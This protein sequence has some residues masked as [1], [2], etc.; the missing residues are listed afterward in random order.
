MQ[1][2]LHFLLGKYL[3]HLHSQLIGQFL[4]CIGVRKHKKEGLSIDSTLHLIRIQNHLLYR[5]VQFHPCL[6]HCTP[7]V[8]A[9][10]LLMAR[11][12]LLGQSYKVL[13]VNITAIDVGKREKLITHSLAHTRHT[14]YLHFHQFHGSMVSK[15]DYNQVHISH[16][17]LDT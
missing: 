5:S 12:T 13:E 9:A 14:K 6:E 10:T 7:R 2:Y 4:Y 16:Q 3:E 17:L 15:L 8:V 11:L 1:Y